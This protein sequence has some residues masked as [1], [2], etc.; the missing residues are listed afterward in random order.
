MLVI[1]LA[2]PE[3]LQGLDLHP[4]GGG[5]ALQFSGSSLEAGLGLGLLH[6]GACE[7]HGP[8][9]IAAIA[10]LPTAIEGIHVAP[11][12]A[13]Q[14]GEAD[15][16]GIKP[17]QHGFLVAGLLCRNLLVGGVIQ[18]ASAVATD[19]LNHPWE[20][21]EIVLKTPE[22]TTG[23]HRFLQRAHYRGGCWGRPHRSSTNQASHANQ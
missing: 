21:F 8:V 15:P 20:R 23:Q 10:K 6:L 22:T 1:A 19:S 7:D 18:A 14:G 3:A 12:A 4:N 2:W 17:H 16:L 9:G 5:W 11:I 13:Q